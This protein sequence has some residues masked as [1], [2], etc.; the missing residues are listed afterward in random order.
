[1]NRREVIAATALLTTLPAIAQTNSAPNEIAPAGAAP[2]STAAPAPAEVLGLGDAE[3]RRSY[4]VG[5]YF[6]AQC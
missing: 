3:K 5:W 2:P 4:I 6:V 1:M